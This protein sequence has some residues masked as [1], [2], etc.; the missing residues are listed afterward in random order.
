[1]DKNKSLAALSVSASGIRFRSISF[2]FLGGECKY[3]LPEH[4]KQF[5]FLPPQEQIMVEICLFFE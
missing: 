5:G 2:I 1:M 4:L 3:P